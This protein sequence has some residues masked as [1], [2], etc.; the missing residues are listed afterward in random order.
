M[1]STDQL[2]AAIEAHVAAVGAGD[3]TTLGTLYASDGRLHDPA[4][5]QPVVSRA[6]I[7]E[8]F[9]S[10][11]SEPREVEIVTIVVTGHDAAVHFRATPAGGETRDV[12]DTMIFDDQAMITVMRAYAG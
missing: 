10:V 8:H 6:A 12:I 5:A 9:G 7:A 2:R 11:L 4:G 1:A 3:A